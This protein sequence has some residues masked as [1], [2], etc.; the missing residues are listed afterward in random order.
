[1]PK[2]QLEQAVLLIEG[3]RAGAEGL[4][5]PDAARLA[6]LD[7]DGVLAQVSAAIA[8]DVMPA[9]DALLALLKS[10]D[11]VA[12]APEAVGLAQYPGGAEAY[13][14]L[15]RMH[16]T[17]EDRKSGAQGKRVSVS[18]DLG[19]CRIIKKKNINQK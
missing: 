12:A 13:A 6:D 15:V 8:Q 2:P 9:F 10:D 16:T 19:G 5:T 4:L 7:A 3:F 17:L 18:V 11:Y 14:A 1:M